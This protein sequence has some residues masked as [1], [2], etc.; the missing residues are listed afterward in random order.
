MAGKKDRKAKK[1]DATVTDYLDD[2]V[3]DDL[4][5]G[6]ISKDRSGNLRQPSTSMLK[7][8]S[9]STAGTLFLCKATLLYRL[10]GCGILPRP[11]SRYMEIASLRAEEAGFISRP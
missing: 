5:G 6:R 11:G 4:S 9:G 3:E 8:A 2:I 7:P 10:E 1:S